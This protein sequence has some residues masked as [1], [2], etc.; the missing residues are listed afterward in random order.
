MAGQTFPL[1]T[2]SK[3]LDLTPRRVNQLV[4]EGVLPRAERGRYEL[5]PVVQA[6]IRY[7]REKALK[8]DI[9]DD[10]TTHRARLVKARADLLEMEREQMSGQLIPAADVQT[11]WTQVLTACRAKLL[12][13]PTKTAPEVFAADNIND[14]KVLLKQSVHEALSELSNVRVEVVNPIRSSES[15]TDSADL[16]TQPDATAESND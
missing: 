11:S 15:A 5:V 8:G 10:Y 1:D 3:L 16:I 14:V 13:I 9:G 12:S 7:L 6:Y 2:I 4:N